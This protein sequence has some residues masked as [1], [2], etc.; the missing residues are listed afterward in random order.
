VH[1][2]QVFIHDDHA[3]HDGWPNIQNQVVFYDFAYIQFR[4]CTVLFPDMFLNLNI[5]RRV[6]FQSLNCSE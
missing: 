2:V 5:S 4:Y 1:D 6:A 3:G